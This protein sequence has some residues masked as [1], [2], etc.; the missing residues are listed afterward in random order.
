MPPKELPLDVR[1]L[2]DPVIGVDHPGAEDA[3]Q[4]DED[5]ELVEGPQH[6]PGHV[7]HALLDLSVVAG[8]LLKKSHHLSGTCLSSRFYFVSFYVYTSFHSRI[9]FGL[10]KFPT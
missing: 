1:F 10:K 9:I 5:G 7:A 6:V 4:D 3:E 8:L 2:E